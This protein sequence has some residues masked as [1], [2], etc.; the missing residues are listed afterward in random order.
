MRGRRWTTFLAV[1]V[2]VAMVGPVTGASASVHKKTRMTA[3]A[4]RIE[5]N[6]LYRA[7]KKHP[8]LINKKSFIKRASL[9]NFRL[10]ITV[11]LRNSTVASNPN[12]ANLDLGASLG[13]RQLDLGGSLS[14]EIVFHDSYDGGALGTV[15]VQLSPGPKALTTTSVPLLWNTDVTD[16]TTSIA[17][18]FKL[19]AGN[20]GCGNFHGNSPVTISGHQ[21]VPYWNTQGDYDAAAAAAGYVPDTPGVDDP[22]RLL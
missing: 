14:G 5:R 6:R 19:G 13:K 12:T 7:V 10:P 21:T 11:R 2:C 16:P 20:P 22:A 17:P 18:T 1:A 4:K 8:R 9:V 3:K 15:D